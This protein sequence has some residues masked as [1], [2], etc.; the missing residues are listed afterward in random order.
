MNGARAMA[1]LALL[2]AAGVG[3]AH[4]ESLAWPTDAWPRPDGSEAYRPEEIRRFL[5]TAFSDEAPEFFRGAR[6]VVVVHAGKLV[7]EAYR[8]AEGYGPDSRFVSWSEAKS[9]TQAL[10]GIA[11]RK[12]LVD[13]AAPAA[14]AQW[15]QPG[16]PRAAITLDQL[17]RMSSGLAWDEGA[18]G[19]DDSSTMLFG[20]GRNDMAAFAADMPLEHPPGEHWAYATGTTMIVSGLVRDA[21]GGDEAAYRAFLDGEL[22]GPLGMQSAVAE[23][24]PAGSFIGGTSFYASARDYARFG[25]LYLRDGV[26]RGRRILPEGWTDYSRSLTPGSEGKYGAHF[27]LGTVGSGED[28][29]AAGLALPDDM[30]QARGMG[31]QF[32]AIVPSRDVVI[33]YNGYSDLTDYAPIDLYFARILALLAEKRS[34]ARD[35]R[36]VIIGR[37]SRPRAPTVGW[38][39]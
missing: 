3:T 21:V 36:G 9:V 35:R 29:A 24:D 14:V 19:T 22:L 30:Y 26:W 27:W 5:E 37:C 6:G 12:G 10:A 8:E 7:A 4:A 20:S 39:R 33:A 15:R 17:L 25:L 16:D 2:L 13:L 18:G 34:F 28:L 32:L 38:S 1:V 11:V 23:F 31:G